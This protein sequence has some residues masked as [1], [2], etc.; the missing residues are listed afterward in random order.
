MRASILHLALAVIT[1]ISISGC[2][3][4]GGSKSI[5]EDSVAGR[6]LEIP[7]GLDDPGRANSMN[8][9]GDTGSTATAVIDSTEPTALSS[10]GVAD[11][12]APDG[13]TPDGP[14]LVAIDDSV[15]GAFS[16]V[17]LALERAALGEIIAR[18]ETA[19]T[20]TVRGMSVTSE[21]VERGFF[22]RMFRRPATRAV[23]GEVVRVV[24]VRP[25]R[26]TSEVVIEDEDGNPADDDLARR[27]AAAIRERLG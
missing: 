23:E 3:L 6:P 1:A 24:R 7:P 25:N 16:R 17:G 10:A 5:Y 26:E 27:L 13:P 12:T 2:G 22:G 4:F 20:Y 11:V 14:A 21:P 19:M 9:P 18:D 8:I 15:T